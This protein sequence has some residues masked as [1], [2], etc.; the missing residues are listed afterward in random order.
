ML[1]RLDSSSIAFLWVAFVGATALSGPA[2]AQPYYRPAAGM[3]QCVAPPF[4]SARTC[5]LS[6]GEADAQD[7]ERVFIPA[8]PGQWVRVERGRVGLG[9]GRRVERAAVVFATRPS[10]YVDRALDADWVVLDPVGQGKPKVYL[11]SPSADRELG[12]EPRGSRQLNVIRDE[13]VELDVSPSDADAFVR[14]FAAS[15]YAA[16]EPLRGPQFFRSGRTNVRVTPEE[17]FVGPEDGSFWSLALTAETGA[18]VVIRHGEVLVAT[19]SLRPGRRRRV[20]VP[21]A[22]GARL[23]IEASAPVEVEATQYAYRASVGDLITVGSARGQLN[24]RPALLLWARPGEGDQEAVEALD[25]PLSHIALAMTASDEESTSASTSRALA[26]LRERAPTIQLHLLYRLDQ[27]GGSL[28]R[29]ACRGRFRGLAGAVRAKACG[30]RLSPALLAAA[31]REVGA[32]DDTLTRRLARRVARRELD[33]ERLDP[34]KSAPRALRV[35]RAGGR[36]EARCIVRGRRW[37]VFQPGVYAVQVEGKAEMRIHPDHTPYRGDVELGSQRF[38]FSG[39]RTVRRSLEA[40]V[41]T[42][43]IP[44]DTPPLLA[45]LSEGAEVPCREAVYVVAGTGIERGFSQPLRES[46][47]VFGFVRVRFGAPARTRVTYRAGGVEG[48]VVIPE[49]RSNANLPVSRN[50]EALELS[51]GEGSEVMVQVSRAELPGARRQDRQDPAA[52]PPRPEPSP[53]DEPGPFS[54][55]FRTRLV[56]RE[57]RDLDSV[58]GGTPYFE[59]APGIHRSFASELVYL[60][61]G[62]PVRVREGDP[63]FGGQARFVVN[64]D[65]FRPRL[66]ASGRFMMQQGA[67]EITYSPRAQVSAVWGISL[68]PYLSLHPTLTGRW[69]EVAP[70]QNVST[71]QVDPDIYTRYDEDHPLLA[72]ASLTSFS[73]ITRDMILRGRVTARTNSPDGGTFLDRVDGAIRFDWSMGGMLLPWMGLGYRLSQRFADRDR[74]NDA[75]QHRFRFEASVFEAWIGEHRLDL[76]GRVDAFI[77]TASETVTGFLTLGYLWSPHRGLRDFSERQLRHRAA[78]EQ[79]LSPLLDRAESATRV[80]FDD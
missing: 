33:F 60:T 65:G 72:E 74:R 16:F 3:A 48:T 29:A 80:T 8:R 66:L 79:G 42:L 57:L 26:A 30:R 77:L 71:F 27:V 2:R 59:M 68:S 75:T 51:S 69:I 20:R 4:E 13:L 64:G 38:S 43:R 44:P 61:V 50:A 31:Y 19:R 45:R 67:E 52:L 18:D 76:G 14:A 7:D 15:H 53:V 34:P 17:P 63:S 78:R 11:E 28:S 35:E 23:R 49:G 9:Y 62:L 6:G 24:Q 22:D 58:A 56:L 70:A 55:S 32:P 73:R 5:E 36:P 21:A 47:R 12:A 39:S 46:D 25:T 40:G 1:Y 41:H 54:A 10:L 37:R